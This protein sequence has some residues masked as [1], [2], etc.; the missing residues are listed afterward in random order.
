MQGRAMFFSCPD[1]NTRLVIASVWIGN[2]GKT[3]LL[4]FCRVCKENVFLSLET[5]LSTIAGT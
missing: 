2:D 4:S 5:F 1:C 3:Y